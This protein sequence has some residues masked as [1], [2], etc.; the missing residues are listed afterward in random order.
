VRRSTLQMSSRPSRPSLRS[1]HLTDTLLLGESAE[2][3]KR[4][5]VEPPA[6]DRVA[7]PE[8]GLHEL[9]LPPPTSGVLHDTS[10]GCNLTG[11][12]VMATSL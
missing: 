1:A 5:L 11:L 4:D 6:V 3:V 9:V 10:W 12:L 8:H 7:L 2:L